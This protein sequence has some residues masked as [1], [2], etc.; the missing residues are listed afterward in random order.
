MSKNEIL[1]NSKIEDEQ[2]FIH[3]HYKNLFKVRLKESRKTI[4]TTDTQS[5]VFALI[6]A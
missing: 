5:L 4:L 6:R 2:S 3:R 1:Q